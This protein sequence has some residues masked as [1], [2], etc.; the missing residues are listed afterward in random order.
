MVAK[1]QS[2]RSQ[3]RK[4]RSGFVAA[5]S[6]FSLIRVS[7]IDD[8]KVIPGRALRLDEGYEVL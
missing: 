2:A 5:P 3:S 8:A 4:E 7:T 6:Y 1:I